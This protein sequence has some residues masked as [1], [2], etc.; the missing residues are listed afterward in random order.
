MNRARDNAAKVK[1]FKQEVIEELK[2]IKERIEAVRTKIVDSRGTQKNF[3]GFL[4]GQTSEYLDRFDS[5]FE[6][7]NARLD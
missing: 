3:N 5:Q 1:N 4:L 7:M 2:D 6:K